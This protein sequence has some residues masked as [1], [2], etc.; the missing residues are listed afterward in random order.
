M[1]SDGEHEFLSDRVAPSCRSLPSGRI[2][3]TARSWKLGSAA[4][5]TGMAHAQADSKFALR[6]GRILVRHKKARERLMHGSKLQ[7]DR[8]VW[9]TMGQLSFPD[10]EDQALLR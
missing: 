9:I 1:A 5:K 3:V 2:K 8:A 7:R 4:E 6:D 10:V